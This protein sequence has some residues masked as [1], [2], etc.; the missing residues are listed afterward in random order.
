MKRT[1]PVIITLIVLSLLGLIFLQVQWIKGAMK[2][3]REQYE[4]DIYLSIG[5][6][7][8]SIVKRKNRETFGFYLNFQT[9]TFGNFI[10]TYTVLSNYQLKAI[11]RD[12]FRWWRLDRSR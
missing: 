4:N 10:P 2:L 8:D 3:K 5:N 9:Q 7:R 1:L 6:I 11:I 12:E